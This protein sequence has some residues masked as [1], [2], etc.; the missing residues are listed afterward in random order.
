M[1]KKLSGKTAIVTGGNSGI[2]EST[3]HLFAQQGANVIIM[4]RREEQGLEV[5]ESINSQGGNSVFI[6]MDVG[7]PNSVY[8]AIEKASQAFG[9]VH[10]L[11]NN[12]N[13]VLTTP[14]IFSQLQTFY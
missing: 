5:Q 14:N 2:G 8:P 7:D 12:A 11:F 6:Q 4:A 1:T 13:H 10:I 3:A 9:D